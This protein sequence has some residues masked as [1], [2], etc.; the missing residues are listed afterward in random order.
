MIIYN[1]QAKSVKRSLMDN[2]QTGFKFAGKMF[3]EF[4]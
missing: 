4:T 1:V 2:I 3:G